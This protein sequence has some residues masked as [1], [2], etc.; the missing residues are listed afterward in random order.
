MKNLRVL[1]S[2]LTL[3][4]FAAVSPAASQDDSTQY[5]L[6]IPVSEDDTVENFPGRDL[7][8]GQNHVRVPSEKLPE[9]L[10]KVLKNKSIYKGWHLSPVYLD[11]NTNLYLITIRGKDAVRVFGLDEYGKPVTYDE[12]SIDH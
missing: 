6:G 12:V 11:K 10:Q 1:I 2:A 3:F 4:V 9:H 7:P 8:P 5:I